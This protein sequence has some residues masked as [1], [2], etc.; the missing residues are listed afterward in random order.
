MNMIKRVPDIVTAYNQLAEFALYVPD[1]G[2]VSENGR[3]I[4]KSS[5]EYANEHRLYA[6]VNTDKTPNQEEVCGDENQNRLRDQ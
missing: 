2:W 3:V 6:D 1:V 5:E 4:Y